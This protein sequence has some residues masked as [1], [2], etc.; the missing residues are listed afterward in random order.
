MIIGTLE[1][2]RSSTDV[3]EYE[4]N[5]I[6]EIIKIER[7]DSENRIC[8]QIAESLDWISMKDT[9]SGAK[10]VKPFKNEP[11]RIPEIIIGYPQLEGKWK[12]SLQDTVTVKE[13]YT[14]YR[15]DGIKKI[16]EDEDYQFTLNGWTL[17]KKQSHVLIWKKGGAE[18][19]WNRL[20]TY[21][22]CSQC[23]GKYAETVKLRDLPS[24][25]KMYGK[26]EIYQQTIPFCSSPVFDTTEKIFQISEI[27]ED[28]TLK[29]KGFEL[30]T[31]PQT[32]KNNVLP[33][34]EEIFKNRPK[35]T[36]TFEKEEEIINELKE[37]ILN[38]L[39][40][41]V[42]YANKDIYV[43]PMHTALLRT[44]SSQAGTAKHF[45]LFHIDFGGVSYLTSDKVLRA[46]KAIFKGDENMLTPDLETHIKNGKPIEIINI[47]GPLFEDISQHILGFLSPGVH[48]HQ[49][50]LDT[51][52]AYP[53]L[54]P[55]DTQ[56]LDNISITLNSNMKKGQVYIFR[57][58]GPQAP[59]HASIKIQGKKNMDRKSFEYRFIVMEI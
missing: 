54:E 50:Y 49:D 4:K 30:M 43:L 24:D 15:S 59:P 57:T 11:K 37:I 32:T 12:T 16:I 21:K 3:C 36:S 46:A 38:H 48:K 22:C 55:K 58:S 23:K 44:A 28:D 10:W 45:P 7:M 8:G 41:D 27:T 17:D 9:F 14:I 20:K 56:L 26:C 19:H 33:V 47:W 25:G 39:K 1:V 51:L 53:Y 29:N 5:L 6:L 13:F 34:L 35:Q 42:K 18:V 40:K 52:I 2:S 31:L